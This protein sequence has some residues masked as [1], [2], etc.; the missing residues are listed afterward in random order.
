MGL[1]PHPER[2]SEAVLGGDDGR[3]LFD[4]ARKTIALAT[5]A[6]ARAEAAP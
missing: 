1:M 3:L 4:A 5:D 6:A 2:M